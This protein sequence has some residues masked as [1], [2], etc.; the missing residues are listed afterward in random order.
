M[1]R[2]LH[3]LLLFL[4]L[5]VN[6]PSFSQ[7]LNAGFE[8]S[9]F[10]GWSGTNCKST[11]DSSSAGCQAGTGTG[12][13]PCIPVFNFTGSSF[14][15]PFKIKAMDIGAVNQ[16]ANAT[17]EKSQFIMQSGFDPI[18]GGTSIPVVC[19]GGGNNSGRLGNQQ[20]N[21]GGESLMYK[22]TVN[23]TNALFT[24]NYAVVL[25][26]GGHAAGQQPYFK[27]RMWAYNSPTDSVSIDCGNYT[28]DASTAAN[29]GGFTT[30]G[31]VLWKSWSAVTIPLQT[32]IG[33]QVSIQ[34]IT[35]DCCPD[36]DA[37]EVGTQG[38]SHFA[39][40]YIDASCAPQEIIPSSP[41]VCA[42][43]SITLT[44]PVGAASY[45]WS[46]PGIVSGGNTNVATVNQ[47]GNYSVVM[48]TIGNS[49]CTYSLTTTMPGNL[50]G[51]GAV[52][53]NSQTICAGGSATL[54][55][56]G[57][58]TY[59][60]APGGETSPFITV[61]PG[62]TTTYSVTGTSATCG[63]G[64]ATA[65]VT[66]NPIPTSPFTV[67]P[68][69]VGFG[70]TITYTGNAAPTDT[71]T[72]N[73]GGGTV[74]SGT[75][76]G[77]Y[78]VSWP[79]SG[80]KSVSLTVTA[81][82]CTSTPTTN[83]VT[84]N[85]PPVIT[86]TPTTVCIGS[87][88]TIT[89]AGASTYVWSNTTAAASL[90]DAPAATT[91]YTVTGT[92]ANGCTGTAVGTITVKPLQ[93]PT[94]SY[95][96]ATVC[97]T[98]GSDPI[99][100]ITTP[101]GTF[102][103][104]PAGLTINPSTGVVTLASSALGTYTVTYTTAGPCP[105][106]STFVINIVNVPVAD[107]TLDEYCQNVANPSPT[108][109]NGG[110]AGV[111]TATAGLAFVSPVVTP[112][113]VDLAGS[114]PGN[115]TVT[116]TIA[117]PGC[118][119]TV[120]TNTII[121]NAV[122]VTTVDDQTV[123]A[124]SPATL[125]AGGATTYVWS[126]GP[127]VNTMTDTPGATTPYT[128]TG[129]T[130][131]CSSSATGTI[132]VNPIPVTTATNTVVCAGVAATLTAGGAT[133]YV[134]SNGPT[135]ST[136]TDTPSA[137]TSYTVTGTSLGC[138]S[139]AVGTITVNPI[140]VVTVND[141]VI[142]VGNCTNLTAVGANTYVWSDGTTANPKN[143][144]PG[145]T[146]SY[147]VTGS[148]LGCSSSDVSTVTI[149]LLPVIT[150]NSPAICA[151]QSATLNASGGSV[152]DWE[153][154]QTANSITVSPLTTTSY[155]VGDNTPGCSGST[156]S[157]V[158]VNPLPNVTAT[159]QT[160][161]VGQSATLTAGGA[162]TYLWS[163]GSPANPLIVSPATTTTYT[164]TGVTAAGCS[165]VAFTSVTVNPLPVITA[166][167]TSVCEGL[168]S[169]L[170]ASG[171]TSYVWSNGAVTAANTIS[172]SNTTSYSVTGTDANGC[173]STGTGTVTV[174]PKPGVDF[175]FSPIPAIVTYPT[176]TFASQTTSDVNFWQ[177]SFGDP[178]DSTG[179]N[180]PAP[181]HTYPSVEATYV[182]TLNVLNGGMCPNSVSHE[183]VIGPEY[184]FFIPNAFSPN[185]DGFNDVFFG[186]GKGIVEY[187][188]MI[189]DRWGNFIFYA[190]DIDKAWDGK[191]NNGSE[192]A[193]Q[194]VYVWKV[195]LTD[196][197]HKKHNF[198]G[199]V[200]IVKGE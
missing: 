13:I 95:N 108:Y 122:P 144:C 104:S 109:I 123:C 44:A 42:G 54:T 33:Q 8:D 35:R 149:T 16:A 195:N 66:V 175:T 70:S 46:G 50:P 7:C 155:T 80:S 31:D 169:T 68:V 112:G 102:T 15:D 101:G 89:A 118:P 53:V 99:P 107:F 137:T 199:T 170:T 20:A 88:G 51:A 140:P 193:Q 64:T 181:V 173:S 161:C 150:V 74:I 130:A 174:F 62:S 67:T 142:C 167:S 128:V 180:A 26:S 187:E 71:Y 184:S 76:Q 179:S 9:N 1:K 177:W 84:V 133:T 24:Y 143:V 132:T 85:P 117:S 148:S 164:V 165:G 138:S 172:P 3:L 5:L 37:N 197:F 200:T 116:N 120:A 78:S 110:S 153:T 11:L 29:I 60:W 57:G 14:P 162:S 10:G 38:G 124:G 111:F 183:V 114:T 39:Y 127:T 90:S 94:F 2:I 134:W 28:V 145:S 163:T 18:A 45:A 160:I 41:A 40:A 100:T 4:A 166:N 189:F 86:V 168:S 125:T 121:I 77:P 92:D 48:T 47:P 185:G 81:G 12:F 171:A 156:I 151:G 131:G 188:L 25:N 22:Y 98:G 136:I 55:A 119:L 186:K 135:V 63:S 115:Y 61:T 79:T 141:P 17:P 83:F 27:I 30:D 73:F 58:V 19:P 49:P 194:D 34:F 103:A 21:G 56:S 97:K 106:V 192:M 198:I 191:A 23:T 59:T 75:G 105:D 139:S 43:V 91:S 178:A 154:G 65:T 152:Y 159:A 196:I 190:D 32:Y 87:S 126:N 93:D 69:C 157:T 182:V 96:P 82:T 147:T 158:T 176:I 36:C 72:W 146:I 129:F 113:E 52:D 6:L